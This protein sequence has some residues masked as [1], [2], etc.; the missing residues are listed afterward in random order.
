LSIT[1]SKKLINL[2]SLSG[3]LASIFLALY[4]Y[5]LGIFEDVQTLQDFVSRAAFLA[6]IVFILIQIMQVVI[7]IIPGGISLAAGVLLFGPLRGF[8]YNYLGICIGSLIL[9]WLG[10]QYGKPLVLRLVNEKTYN[11]YIHWLDNQKRFDRLF[12]LAIFL[13]IAPDDALCLMASLTAISFKRFTW[14]I[15]LAKPA[16]IY[17]YSAVLLYGGEQLIQFLL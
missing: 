17:L 1:T 13:P 6:P 14:I 10:R 16:S 5:H 12:A 9:F 15:F 3:F 4:F 11:K 2:I 8:I 7:P